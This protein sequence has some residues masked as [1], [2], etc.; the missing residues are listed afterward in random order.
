M[1]TKTYEETM[2]E[3]R[4]NRLIQTVENGLSVLTKDEEPYYKI[5]YLSQTLR[6][7]MAT[8]EIMKEEIKN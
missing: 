3:S 1:E 4:I 5:G 6:T 7:A 2:L 8:L